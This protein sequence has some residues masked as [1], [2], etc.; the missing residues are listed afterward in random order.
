M[1]IKCKILLVS[2]P[3][4]D[5]HTKAIYVGDRN[6]NIHKLDQDEKWSIAVENINVNSISFEWVPEE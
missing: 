4:Y 6:N 1:F 3:F 2:E 5:K